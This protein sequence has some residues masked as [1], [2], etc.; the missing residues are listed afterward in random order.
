M[1]LLRQIPARATLMGY[2]LFSLLTFYFLPLVGIVAS[3]WS[4][5]L[6]QK[7][8]QIVRI[9]AALSASYLAAFRDIFGSLVIPLVT[10][11]SL[12]AGTLPRSVPRLTI[13]IFT[14]FLVVFSVAVVSLAIVLQ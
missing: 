7:N 12:P 5:D 10:A 11:F 14:F 6:L 3:L 13:A 4:S 8:V 1:R 2:I 9:T